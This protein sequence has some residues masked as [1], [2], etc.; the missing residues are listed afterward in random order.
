[1]PVATKSRDA[2]PKAI[3]YNKGKNIMKIRRKNGSNLRTLK[4]GLNWEYVFTPK[5]LPDG[6]SCTKIVEHKLL[7]KTFDVLTVVSDSV[8]YGL[9]EGKAINA[10]T[11][12]FQDFFSCLEQKGIIWSQGCDSYFQVWYVGASI[13]CEEIRNFAEAL[14][15][16]NRVQAIFPEIKGTIEGK[17]V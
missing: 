4:R 3:R 7:C 6:G 11:R 16:I 14:G 5:S 10:I 17:G 12:T 13:D 2:T 9:N 8:S 15:V 1:M